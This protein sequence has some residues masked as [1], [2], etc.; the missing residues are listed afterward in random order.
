MGKLYKLDAD[1]NPVCVS[2]D[3]NDIN[4]WVK[5]HSDMRNRLVAETMID[6][7]GNFVSTVFFGHTSSDATV[8]YMF[9]T[10][11]FG[12]PL[13]GEMWRYRTWAEAEA[14]HAAAVKRCKAAKD[15]AK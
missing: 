7:D 2:E 13:N 9:Q 8:P 4:A 1:H 5:W 3:I 15:Q 14:G 12:G 6:D 10:L 11:V